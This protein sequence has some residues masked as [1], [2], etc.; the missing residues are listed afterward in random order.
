MQNPTPSRPKSR[1]RK[2]TLAAMLL[3]ASAFLG[4]GACTSTVENRDPMG[5]MFP[6]VIGKSLEDQEMRLPLSEPSVLL[7]G[8]V[9]DAQF[10]ADRW[11]I[12]LLQLAPDVRIFE[13]PTLVGFFPFLFENTIDGGM[14]KGIPE[15]DWK[16]VVTIYGDDADKVLEFTGNERPRNMRV[17]LLDSN[18]NVAWFH[19]RGFS[20]GKMLELNEAISGLA[21]D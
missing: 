12:G 13:V 11:L 6:A 14:R 3:G 7:L 1:R 16:S 21:T 15:E 2:L 19:D 17:L 10:D 8:Y 9:Q 5:E 20:A 4:L 18:G